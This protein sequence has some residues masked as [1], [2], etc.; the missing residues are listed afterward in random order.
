MQLLNRQL[1]IVK[2]VD[3]KPLFLSIY[4]S[5]HTYLTPVASLLPLQLH[6]RRNPAEH[7]LG[8]MLP[9]VR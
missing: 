2:F 6:I 8:C 9:V 3:L 4:C 5:L 7:S 1:G